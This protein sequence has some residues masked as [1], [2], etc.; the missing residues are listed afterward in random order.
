MGMINDFRSGQLPASDS[1]FPEKIGYKKRWTRALHHSI[2]KKS[3]RWTDAEIVRY[4]AREF[5]VESVVLGDFVIV[6]AEG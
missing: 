4:A 1:S 3:K 6:V 2:V 5:C